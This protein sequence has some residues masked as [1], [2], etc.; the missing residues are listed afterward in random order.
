MIKRAQ[1]VATDLVAV[2]HDA[3]LQLEPMITDHW[4]GKWTGAGQY[5]YGYA[6]SINGEQYTLSSH[7]M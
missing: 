4:P 3:G 6:G 5:F 2:H 7:I 1:V